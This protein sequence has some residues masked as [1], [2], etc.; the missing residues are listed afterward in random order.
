MI[1]KL[2]ISSKG[3]NGLKRSLILCVII[4][5]ALL[6]SAVGCQREPAPLS[7]EIS[8]TLLISEVSSQEN[9]IDLSSDVVSLENSSLAEGQNS[10]QSAS[11][12]SKHPSQS[13][14]PTSQ[15]VISSNQ[16][17]SDVSEREKCYSVLY[18]TFKPEFITN[19]KAMIQPS[20]FPE[21]EA[22][23]IQSISWNYNH[24]VHDYTLSIYFKHD[25]MT[26]ERCLRYSEAIKK[27]ADI[28]KVEYDDWFYGDF[29]EVESHLAPPSLQS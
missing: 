8:D 26:S 12:V 3:L 24:D 18:L 28:V 22:D 10:S 1:C 27:R 4:V 16:D 21:L 11:I 19:E 25:A 17:S 13:S 15:T 7:G 14:E 9:K 5:G 2:I 20:F 6:I 29:P 23:C